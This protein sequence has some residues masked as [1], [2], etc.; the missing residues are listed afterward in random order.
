VA[1]D[2]LAGSTSIGTKGLNVKDRE[3]ILIADSAKEF[4]RK[5]YFALIEIKKG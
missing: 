5:A 3:N 4:P 2:W 1:L